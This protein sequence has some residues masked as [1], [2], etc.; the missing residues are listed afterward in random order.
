MAAA[1]TAESEDGGAGRDYAALEPSSLR[2]QILSTN[3]LTE[4]GH[5]PPVPTRPSPTR[6]GEHRHKTLEGLVIDDAQAE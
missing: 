3:T 6:E 1:M 2:G 4:A 5:F